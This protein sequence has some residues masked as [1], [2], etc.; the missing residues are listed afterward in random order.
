MKTPFL[1]IDAHQDLAYSALTFERDYRRSAL[2]TRRLEAGALAPQRNGH[3][4]LGWPEYQRGQVAVVFATLFIASRGAME[5]WESQVYLDTAEARRLWQRQIDYYQ[6]LAGDSPDQFRLI[7][8]GRQLQDLLSA[9]RENP[10]REPLPETDGA[11]AQPVTHP[12]GLVLL[13]ENAEGLREPAELE[14]WYAQGV[15]LVGPVWAGEGARF[16]GGIKT[17]GGFTRE[18][19]ALLEVM[20]GLGLALDISH[21]NE[22]SA[23]EALDRFDGS[24]AATHA[25]CRALLG[26]EGSPRHLSDRVIRSLVERGGVMGISPYAR[27]LRPGWSHAD[28]PAQTNLEHVAAHID[29]VCQLAGSAR[30]VGLGTDFDGGWGWPHVPHELNTV[31]DLQLLAP[32]LAEAGYSEDDIR[33]VMGGNWAAFLE[34]SLGR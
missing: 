12:V 19:Q 16:C 6:R 29:H 17:T 28:D 30:N 5:E 13:M 31:A 21:M 8:E 34:R 14:D 9:W 4:L 23:L 18:G 24:L 15:R 20:S 25:N 7:G 22:R 11:E 2:E 33:A 32:R 1:V 10:A 3:S 27:W 26:R